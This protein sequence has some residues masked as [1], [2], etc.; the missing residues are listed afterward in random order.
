VR[1][2]GGSS[3]QVG[4]VYMVLP[5]LILPERADAVLLSAGLELLAHLV[6][7]APAETLRVVSNETLSGVDPL[8]RLIKAPLLGRICRRAAQWR[9]EDAVRATS[10][11]LPAEGEAALKA[12]NPN[13]TLTRTRTVIEP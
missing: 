2:E 10:A 4:I 7:R 3:G 6:E 9:H 13:R 12:A 11:K 1:V 5:L 8:L